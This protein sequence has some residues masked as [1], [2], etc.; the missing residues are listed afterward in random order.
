MDNLQTNVVRLL[1]HIKNYIKYQQQLYGNVLY[2]DYIPTGHKPNEQSHLSAE[3]QLSQLYEQI[4]LCSKCQLSRSRHKLVFG[5]GNPHAAIMLIGEAPGQDEDAQ[6]KPFVGA[7][8]QLLT[9][10][11]AAINLTRDEVFITNIIKCRPPQN[12]DPLPDEQEACISILQRQIEIIRPKFILLLGRIAAQALLKTTD[13]IQK[14]RGRVH[15]F[16]DAKV[17]VTYHPAALLRDQQ[18]KRPTWE[19]VQLL[20]KLYQQDK[21]S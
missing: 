5:A 1:D 16:K 6:G 14:L 19:D 2:S 17:I 21:S 18:L 20:Q 10:I 4:N 15:S 11:L 3:Q 7:A 12:R 9:K 8:G 13:S